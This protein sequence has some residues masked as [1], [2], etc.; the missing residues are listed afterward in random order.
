MVQSRASALGCARGNDLAINAAAEAARRATYHPPMP[1]RPSGPDRQRRRALATY[2]AAV[3]LLSSSYIAAFTIAAIAAP[4]MTGWPG[5]SGL[6]SSV[7]VVGTAVAATLLSGIMARRGRRLGIIIGI[8]AAVV[9]AAGSL[10]ATAIGSFPLLLLAGIGL[11]IGNAAVYLA[12]YAAADLY[13]PE[14]RAGALGL[15]VWGSTIGAVLGPNLITPAEAVAPLLGLS[16][17]AGAFGLVLLF[18]VAALAVAILGPRAPDPVRPN[19]EPAVAVPRRPAHQLLLELVSQPRGRIALA[20]LTSSQLVMTLVMTMTPLHLHEA[21]HGLG[22]VG[23]VISAHVLGMF[24]FSPFTGRLV[25]GLGAVPVI[26]TGFV[27]LTFAGLLAAVVPASSGGALAAPLLLLGLGWN[28]GFV[29]GSSLLAAE[30]GTANV[31]RRQGIAD[32]LVWTVAA[33]ASFSAGLV[34][35]AVSFAALALTA[36]GVALALALF[37]GFT[38]RRA[39]PALA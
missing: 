28:L 37:V 19:E 8:A 3:A 32:S 17:L 30:A 5:S 18:A 35:A 4:E 7:A 33:L 29:G 21:G 10:L 15:V 38:T 1:P 2:F 36:A 14:R 11:G 12:R 34:V 16:A 9:G 22:I 24:A 39:R 6:P 25:D 26:T 27:L 20:A 31:A 23:F 13:P